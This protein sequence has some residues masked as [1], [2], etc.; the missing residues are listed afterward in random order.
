MK[1]YLAPLALTSDGWQEEFYFSVNAE[2]N[3]CNLNQKSE[4][5][6]AELALEREQGR[7]VSVGS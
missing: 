4:N 3:I 7:A 6:K 1:N 2:G 5:D